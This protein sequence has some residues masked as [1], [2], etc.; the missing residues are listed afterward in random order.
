MWSKE[1]STDLRS[2]VQER[3]T[4]TRET[5]ISEVGP[6]LLSTAPH[7][8]NE[9]TAVVEALL[10]LCLLFPNGETPH[11]AHRSLDRTDVNGA[12]VCVLRL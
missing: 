7:L 12:K 2:P 11:P 10:M 9:A 1:T 5:G 3:D 8:H 4:T 6:G